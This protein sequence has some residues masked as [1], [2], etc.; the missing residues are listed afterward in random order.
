MSLLVLRADRVGFLAK[1]MILFQ[2]E[3]NDSSSAHGPRFSPGMS[4]TFRAPLS[5]DCGARERF[6]DTKTHARSEALP[7]FRQRSDETSKRLPTMAEGP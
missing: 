2:F 5:N 6:T 3:F 7:D 1:F 4:C